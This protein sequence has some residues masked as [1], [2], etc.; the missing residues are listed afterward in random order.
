MKIALFNIWLQ[1]LSFLKIEGPQTEAFAW[2][3]PYRCTARPVMRPFSLM[4]CFRV[5]SG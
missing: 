3:R 2:Y 4:A 1:S 5:F